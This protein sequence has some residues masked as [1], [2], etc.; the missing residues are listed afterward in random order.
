M[1]VRGLS[2]FILLGCILQDTA[3]GDPEVG[4]SEPG[5][6]G[7]EQCQVKQIWALILQVGISTLDLPQNIIGRLPG[8]GE[9]LLL[10]SEREKNP[11]PRNSLERENL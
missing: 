10:V 2:Y 6:E 4:A 1:R 5:A 7:Q 11:V 9:V 8:G 3:L